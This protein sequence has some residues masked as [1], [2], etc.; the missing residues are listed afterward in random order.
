V[1]WAALPRRRAARRR[2]ARRE[3]FD[4]KK[5]FGNLGAGIKDAGGKAGDAIKGAG[6]KAGGA[7][8][9]AGGKALGGLKSAGG[10]I[11][12]IAGVVWKWLK[13]LGWWLLGG[14]GLCCL[15]SSCVMAAR[16]YA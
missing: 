15:C 6:S 9:G 8:K 7:I 5:P 2:A 13:S 1:R 14:L 4:I 3:T 16:A 11:K 12:N 10:F